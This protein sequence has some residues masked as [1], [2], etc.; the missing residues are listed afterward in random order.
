MLTAG[1]ASTDDRGIAYLQACLQQTGLVQS[2]TEWRLPA[3]QFPASADSVPDVILTDLGRDSETAL[4]FAAQTHRVR[5]SACIIACS[6]SQQPSSQ[7]LMQAMRSGVRE[8]L[9][10]P[11][12]PVA[13]RDALERLITE[14]G[15][16]EA[17]AD[18]LIAVIGAKGGVGATT[19]AVNLAA[20][21]ALLT[22]QRVSLFDFGRPLG[23]VSLV[24]DL[25]P[26]FSVR[27]AVE[28]I[29]RLDSHLLSGLLTNHKTGLQ[30]L[31][32][33]SHPDEWLNTSV[34]ALSRILN[35]A[36]ASSD[37]VLADLGTVYSSEW[38]PVL[39]LARLIVLVAETDV[40]SLWGAERHLSTLTSFGLDL[41][42]VRIMINRWH[43]ADEEALKAF[44]S[45]IKR[46]I[47]ARLPNDFSQVNDAVN[48]GAVLSRNHN[49]PL[50][51]KFR[52][53]AREFAGVPAQ[54]ESRQRGSIFGLL[55]SSKT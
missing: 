4:A 9:S 16:E 24:L 28:N 33:A 29:E 31:A 54:K 12:D 14:Q 52:A 30:V 10:Q 34:P 21:M 44:E 22:K 39:R 25:Q 23:H 42:R 26:R 8:F 43:R 46:P 40:P 15:L 18:K 51:G 49:D 3:A 17:G 2:V 5:P 47:F 35:V 27:D 32:G 20:Q 6:T 36:Q 53:M 1:V 13:L 19:V 7:L 38:T 48:R 50:V 11:I 41:K 45:R 37:F 55:S